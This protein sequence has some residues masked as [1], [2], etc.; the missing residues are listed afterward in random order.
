M[1]AVEVKS[2]AV[3]FPINA[4][5]ATGVSGVH[6]VTGIAAAGTGSVLLPS[7]MKGKFIRCRPVGAD[8]QV[9]VSLGSAGQTLTSSPASAAGTGNAASGATIK[10]GEFLDGMTPTGRL[11]D[12]LYLNYINV[13]AVACTLE[14]W[15]SEAVKQ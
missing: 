15:V 3:S 10:D 1:S 14:F 6:R 12:N 7:G 8:V 2:A 4:A 13:G 5:D 9:G 11:V